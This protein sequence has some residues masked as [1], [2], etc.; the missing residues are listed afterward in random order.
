[1]GGHIDDSCTCRLLEQLDKNEK[2]RPV[3]PS[4]GSNLPPPHA[5]LT[6][7]TLYWIPYI[8]LAPV[9]GGSD[10]LTSSHTYSSES[11]FHRQSLPLDAFFQNEQ[12]LGPRLFLLFG[13]VH[14][15]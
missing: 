12:S 9:H 6:L 1:M 11:R 4:R 7:A 2:D 3:F 5:P 15:S 13:W 8:D 10:W 14:P